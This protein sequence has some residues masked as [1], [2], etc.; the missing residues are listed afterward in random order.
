M[1]RLILLRLRE[2][3]N[4]CTLFATAVKGLESKAPPISIIAYIEVVV[5][6]LVLKVLE[7]MGLSFFAASVVREARKFSTLRVGLVQSKNMFFSFKFHLL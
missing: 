3:D 7:S 1:E 2:G 4:F 5:I 6:L